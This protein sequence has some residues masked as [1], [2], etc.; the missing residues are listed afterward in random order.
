[1]DAS[2]IFVFLF[3][4]AMILAII[5]VLIMIII[6]FHY[7]FSHDLFKHHI[8]IIKARKKHDDKNK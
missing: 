5:G 1:M 2:D 7:V 6:Y 3:L 4:G 8:K